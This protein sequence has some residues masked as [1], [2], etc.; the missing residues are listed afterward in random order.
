MKHVE[1]KCKNCGSELKID[2]DGTYFCPYC[3]SRYEK[4]QDNTVIK[5]AKQSK[6]IKTI[7]EGSWT[8]K[9]FNKAKN[10]H[11]IDPMQYIKVSDM[12]AVTN[13]VSKLAEFASKHDNVTEFLKK[14]RNMK[15]AS[16][17]ANMGISCLFLGLIVPYSMMKY[18][19]K[20]QN[21]NKEFHVQSE[22]EKQLEHNFKGRIA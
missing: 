16:V 6:I 2:T 21:G 1:L 15:I 9:L 11:L 3:G 19:E 18:R 20:Q 5:A 8:D 10:T 4:N 17:A 7:I 13:N 14:C 22:I 12:D